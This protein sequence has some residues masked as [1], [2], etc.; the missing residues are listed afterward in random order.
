MSSKFTRKELADRKAGFF[1]MGIFSRK[2][3]FHKGN[4]LGYF[5]KTKLIHNKV[6]YNT[7]MV[8]I[9]NNKV[10]PFIKG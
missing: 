9:Y 1:Y 2:S 10:S 6:I 5:I 3:E 4:D 8:D 7:S